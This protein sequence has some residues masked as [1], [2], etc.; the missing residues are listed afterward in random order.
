M[1]ENIYFRMVESFMKMFI[2]M[3]DGLVV[4][5]RGFFFRVLVFDFE[6]LYGG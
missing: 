5:N 4:K 1:F 3:R 2:F 6:Y